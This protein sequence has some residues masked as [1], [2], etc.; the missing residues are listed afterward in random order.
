MSTHAEPGSDWE[1]ISRMTDATSPAC[2]TLRIVC[3]DPAQ[4][5]TS[6]SSTAPL[7]KVPSRAVTEYHESL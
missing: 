7:Y 1:R 4:P 5:R 6:S 3:S 2:V